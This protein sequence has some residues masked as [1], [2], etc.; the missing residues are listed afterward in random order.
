MK[1]EQVCQTGLVDSDVGGPIETFQ[2]ALFLKAGGG[3][4]VGDVFLFAPVRLRRTRRVPETGRNRVFL[5]ERRRPDRAGWPTWRKVSNVSVRFSV[6]AGS[7]LA[8]PGV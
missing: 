2:R 6:Q 4:A 7:T 1:T 5:F 3:H 8:P